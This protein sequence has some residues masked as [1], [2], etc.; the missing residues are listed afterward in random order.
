MSLY[1]WYSPATSITGRALAHELGLTRHSPNDKNRGYGAA[2]PPVRTTYCIS[3]GA[4]LP[5]RMTERRERRLR[6]I[7]YLNSPFISEISKN[8]YQ[9][10]VLMYEDGVSV[11]EFTNDKNL[12]WSLMYPIVGRTRQHFKG[13]GFTFIEMKLNY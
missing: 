10:L 8:K 4:R 13:S 6:R 5:Q 11:P 2:P 1:L 7:E 12:A 3:W 9:A